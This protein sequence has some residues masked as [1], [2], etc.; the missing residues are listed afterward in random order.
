MAGVSPDQLSSPRGQGNDVQS[1]ERFSMLYSPAYFWPCAHSWPLLDKK[2]LTSFTASLRR[3]VLV[4]IIVAPN[5]CCR[6]FYRF[7]SAAKIRRFLNVA[8]LCNNFFI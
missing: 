8:K 3:Y 1:A 7:V 5:C 2:S 6:Q 4:L